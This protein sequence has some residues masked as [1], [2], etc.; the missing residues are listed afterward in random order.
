M[1]VGLVG[2]N[3]SK[4]SDAM[5]KHP[6]SLESQRL[7][8]EEYKPYAHATLEFYSMICYVQIEL[9]CNKKSSEISCDINLRNWENLYFIPNMDRRV[10]KK[11]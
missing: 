1:T 7:Q 6:S 8:V 11:Y 3:N 2:K 5:R 4:I 9:K 10:E